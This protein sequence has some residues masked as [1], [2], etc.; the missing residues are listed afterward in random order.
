MAHFCVVVIGDRLEEQLALFDHD[1][2]GPFEVEVGDEERRRMWGAATA[3]GVPSGS[4]HQLAQ[5]LEEQDCDTYQAR[6]DALWR[7]STANPHGKWD[8]YC[9]GGRYSGYFPVRADAP[10]DPARR[11]GEPSTTDILRIA[12]ATPERIDGLLSVYEDAHASLVEI[13]QASSQE[14]KAMLDK[15]G[16][17]PEPPRDAADVIRIADIDMDRARADVLKGAR[18]RFR[19][20]QKIVAEHGRPRPRSSVIDALREIEFSVDHE[21]FNRIRARLSAEFR[22]QPTIARAYDTD[23]LDV[24][25]SD[26]PV[27]TFG[28]DE[29]DFLRRV[30]NRA[31]VPYAFVHDGVWHETPYEGYD[32][33]AQ[34]FQDAL[35]SDPPTTFVTAVDCHE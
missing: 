35:R 8:W 25:R 18:E 6:G 11:L 31:L 4:L 34:R 32:G 24:P 27:E 13:A 3:D 20:W 7:L 17:A 5:W 19:R 30:G 33:Y 1:R 23:T 26:C 21:E 12:L 22:A 29:A 10:V 9:V 16:P 28:Y 2:E 15:L 14:R